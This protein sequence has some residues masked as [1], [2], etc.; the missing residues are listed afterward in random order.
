VGRA[1]VTTRPPIVAVRLR[2]LLMVC[3]LEGKE[4]R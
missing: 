2:A 1:G 3:L 4:V